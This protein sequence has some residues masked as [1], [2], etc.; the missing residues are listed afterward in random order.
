MATLIRDGLRSAERAFLAAGPSP[1]ERLDASGFAADA[2]DDYCPRCGLTVGP[3]EFDGERCATCRSARQRYGGVVRLGAY[4]G[5][6]RDAIHEFK[7]DRWP[8]MG[9]RLGRALGA[10]IRERLALVAAH[11]GEREADVVE[12]AAIVPVPS[13][14]LRRMARGID[15]SAILSRAVARAAG[16]PLQRGLLRRHVPAQAGLSV[17]ARHRNMRGTMS[18]AVPPSDLAGLRVLVVV[19]DVLT[20]GATM[21]EAVRALSAAFPRGEAPAM[22]AAV[23]ARADGPERRPP[24]AEGMRQGVREDGQ[25]GG[26]SQKNWSPPPPDA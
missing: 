6:L 17:V 7:F 26:A 1:E 3:H 22:L 13:T 11:A 19:D 18:L 4:G 14:L 23:I 12:R 24:V 5:P 2:P 15:H 16:L 20:T 8:T 25:P 10:A 21:S 9:E